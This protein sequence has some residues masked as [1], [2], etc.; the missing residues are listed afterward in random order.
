MRRFVVFAFVVLSLH[1]GAQSLDGL[2][3]Y[4]TGG[5]SMTNWHGQAG[6]A[7]MNIELTR[8]ISPR[9]EIAFVAAPMTVH[10]PRSWF[11]NQFGDGEEN[12]RAISGSL[13]VRRNFHITDERVHLYAE[14]STGPMW[15]EKRVPASTSRFNFASQIGAGLI[16]LPR[17]AMPVLLGY[18]FMHI[19]NGGYAPR[20]PG[21]NVSSIAIGTMIRWRR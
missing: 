19:S 16:F 11:G 6:V 5:K 13:L 21:L 2:S 8:A 12:V 15:A 3:V 17:S 4:A 9:T 10:Q 14:A 7:S 1:A 20:N 18:R